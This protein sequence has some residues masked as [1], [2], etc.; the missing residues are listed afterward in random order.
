[1]VSIASQITCLTIVYSAV[2]SDADQRKH[3]SSALLAFVWGI[4][5]GPVNS[6]HKWPVMRKMFPFDDFIMINNSQC[7]SVCQSH[8]AEA[9]SPEILYGFL[10]NQICL[11]YFEL[12][13]CFITLFFH[14]PKRSIWIYIT[15][16]L[17]CKS[18]SMGWIFTQFSLHETNE[19]LLYGNTW[20]L[21]VANTWDYASQIPYFLF[22]LLIH[23]SIW[24]RW[25]DYPR[26]QHFV[27][28]S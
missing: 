11:M 19:C 10:P 16:F 18:D 9:I 2:Y 6:P 21:M 12:T 14:Q 13:Q 1:M 22:F 25:T 7:M 8:F 15:L 5:W 17:V 28:Q 26:I 3:Q 4:H 24:A 20:F 23:P 27:I